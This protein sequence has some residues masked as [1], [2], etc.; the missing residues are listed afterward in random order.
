MLYEVSP[1]D[2]V[3][4]AGVASLLLATAALACLIPARQAM[5][6]D[7]IAALRG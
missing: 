2:P 3:T 4:L 1:A 5:K 6:V 7:P